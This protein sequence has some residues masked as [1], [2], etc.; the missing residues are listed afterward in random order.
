M[1]IS[2]T[3][4]PEKFVEGKIESGVYNNVGEVIRESLRLLKE[5]DE[6][7]VKWREQIEQGWLQA[8]RGELIDGDVAFDKLEERIKEHGRKRA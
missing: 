7:R 4:E 3:P 8:Q 2:L 1:N 5:H 6:M